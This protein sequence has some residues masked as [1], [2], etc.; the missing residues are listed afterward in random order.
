[1]PY[2]RPCD[3][4]LCGHLVWPRQ[5]DSMTLRL[6]HGARRAIT[7]WTLCDANCL[8]Q[9]LALAS[10]GVRVHPVLDRA[11]AGGGS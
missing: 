2:P 11:P 1:M 8:H 5:P 4:P 9:L 3:N 10:V 7:T 6:D